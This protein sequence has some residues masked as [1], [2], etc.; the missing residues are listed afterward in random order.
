MLKGAR[1]VIAAPDGDGRDRARSRTR[2]S[3]PAA[4]ATS[5]PGAIGS[6]LAQ[7]L[8][9][10]AAARLGVYLHGAAGDPV[11]ERLGDA[12][13]LASDLPDAIALARDAWRRSPSASAGRQAAGLRGARRRRPPGRRPARR[14]PTPTP[15]PR[16]RASTDAPPTL[17]PD[18]GPARRGRPAAAPADGLAGDRPRRAGRQP[19]RA[20]R[21]RRARDAALPGRQGRRLRPRRDPGR[22]GPRGGRRGRLLR[23]DDGRGARAPGRR[24]STRPIRVLYPVPA[25]VRVGGRR[26]GDRASA[27]GDPGLLE[28]LARGRWP[29]R[30]PRSARRS[31]LE[32]EVET[33]LGRGG[34]TRPTSPRSPPGIARRPRGPLAGVWTH[35]QASED[36]ATTAAQLAVFD[37]A[38]AAR[39]GPPACR[40]RRRHLAA[41]G[42]LLT[43]VAA[44]DG[45]RPGPARLRPRARRARR[46][47]A[48]RPDVARPVPP[49]L[50]LHARPVRVADLPA[51]HGISYGPT[52]RTARP[53]RIATLPLGYGD[54]CSRGLSNRAEALVRGRRVP[55]V[56]NVAM[57]AVMADVTDVPGPPVTTDDEFALIGRPGS[58]PD[59]RRRP[60]AARAPPTVG[61]RDR[62]GPAPASGVRCAGRAGRVAD[63]HGGDLVAR[64]RTLERRHLRSRGRR[65]RQSREPVAVD[66]DRAS[67]A[68]SSAPAATRSS[69]RP[70]ARRPSR[71]ASRSSRPAGTLAAGPSS[72]PSRSIATG[73]RAA[74]SS[75]RPSAARWPAPARSVRRASPSRPSGPASAASRSTRPPGSPSG[76]SATSS[77][78][79]PGIEHVMFALRGAAAYEAF[80]AALTNTSHAAIGRRR[81]GARW[82]PSS[83]PRSS[84]TSSS[85]RSRARSSCA[86]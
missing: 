14:P 21:A 20:A 69:S 32:L 22:A 26:A 48:A 37:A 16:E 10:F 28:A 71:S 42:G 9:P 3:R 35:L 19:R 24:A 55:L 56:G 25:G 43:E 15:R 40:S 33:G 58:E 17:G 4:P 63:A 65:H 85:S 57:D 86:A 46:R 68:R 74:R 38:V 1:T 66:G 41:S 79:S 70:C 7:G 27:V 76:P 12:G 36:A 51:G 80:G 31:T 30:R 78:R 59:H 13:L 45:V 75:R 44:L 77:R 39:C 23:R 6:L 5:W 72:M 61:G 8:A 54:G 52:F 49:V 73:A 83:R 53:S 82:S 29:R 67:A 50:S 2:P 11:R 34:C 60:G 18:R 84:A 64:D 62:D 47:R 81:R